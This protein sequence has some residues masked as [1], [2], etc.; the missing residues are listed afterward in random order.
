[1]NKINQQMTTVKDRVPSA[2]KVAKK[3]VFLN[4]RNQVIKEYSR[5]VMYHYSNPA[6]TLY[7]QGLASGELY[8]G[9]GNFIE[10]TDFL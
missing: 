2:T 10:R 8:D 7:K 1:M 5:D 4:A 3:V 6:S 9:N